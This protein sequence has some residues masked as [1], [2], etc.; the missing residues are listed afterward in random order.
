MKILQTRFGPISYNDPKVCLTKLRQTLSVATT[1]PSLRSY[2][3]GY[4]GFL[5]DINL[6][7]F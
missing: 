7:A 4:G 1:R 6:V 5:M 2:T 3:I